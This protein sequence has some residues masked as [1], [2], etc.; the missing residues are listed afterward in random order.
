MHHLKDD[1]LVKSMSSFRKII[2]AWNIL[3]NAEKQP[4][5]AGNTLMISLL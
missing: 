5:H 3:H 1:F 2:Q 4:K